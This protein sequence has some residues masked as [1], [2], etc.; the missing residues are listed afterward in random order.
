M[1]FRIL[2]LTTGVI[3]AA[4]V[5]TGCASTDGSMP[6]MDMGPG[7]GGMTSTPAPAG[8]G[9]FNSADEVF[10]TT[11]IPH[12]EQAIKM[13]DQIL[14]KEGIDQRV[15]ALAEQFKANQGPEIQTMKG[16]LE[17][18]G[19][20]YDDSMSDMSGMPGMEPGDGMITEADIAAL[21]AASGVEASKLFLESMISC[22]QGAIATAEIGLNDGQNADVAALAQQ[23][24]DAQNT[25]ITTMQD[26]LATL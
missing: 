3:A 6:G 13:A 19:I 25:Q 1:R 10:L 17:D 21:N 7:S 23:I 9:S 18:W 22:R 2:A 24:I 15:V 14:A 16:W 5:L 12:H 20:P 8:Q 11:M 4:L 26:I